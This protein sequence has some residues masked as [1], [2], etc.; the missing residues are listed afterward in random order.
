MVR[1]HGV[2]SDSEETFVFWGVPWQNFPVVFSEAFQWLCD[3]FA[4]FSASQLFFCFCGK[5]LRSLVPIAFFDAGVAKE[6]VVLARFLKGITL[7]VAA[8]QP[9]D[10]HAAL[11]KCSRSWKG[12][13][14]CWG[15]ASLDLL[16][17]EASRCCICQ[18]C[19]NARCHFPLCKSTC[20]P[21]GRK[22][23]KTSTSYLFVSFRSFMYLVIHLVH[24]T[25]CCFPV[26]WLIKWILN[27]HSF[28]VYGPDR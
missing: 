14:R 9:G 26:G 8:S 23:F 4:L 21:H 17:P 27:L 12:P 16:K 25:C 28:C 3:L 15:L 24:R 20:S 10:E 1:L 22:H 7:S 19:G 13:C 11:L 2:K 18:S 6:A 5:Y